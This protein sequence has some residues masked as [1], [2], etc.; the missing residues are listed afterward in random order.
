[1]KNTHTISIEK[2]K[3][4]SHIIF[5]TL[6]EEH[7]HMHGTVREFKDKSKKD[8]TQKLL[9]TIGNHQNTRRIHKLHLSR[10]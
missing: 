1:M 10:S 7:I 5:S 3:A 9:V 8:E 6:H 4:N 2:H